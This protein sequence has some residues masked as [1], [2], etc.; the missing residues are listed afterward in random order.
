MKTKNIIE[1]IKFLIHRKM[2]SI[3]RLFSQLK[4]RYW[5][6]RYHNQWTENPI[7][8]SSGKYNQNMYKCGKCGTIHYEFELNNA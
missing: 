4:S 3:R 2:F 1:I 8:A 6:K 5:C 7:G